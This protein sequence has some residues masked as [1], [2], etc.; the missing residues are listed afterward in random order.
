MKNKEY[1]SVRTGKIIPSKDIS[2]D[3]LKFMFT[4][5][6]NKLKI[7]GYFDKYF[8]MVCSD[9]G[10]IPGI[11]DE[12]INGE[13]FISLHRRNLYP[14]IQNLPEYDEDTLFDV[15]EFLHD[16]CSKGIK[17]HYHGFNQ[18]CLHFDEFDDIKGQEHFRQLFNVPLKIY[19]KGFEISESGEVLALADNGLTGLFE[20][21]KPSNDEQ[22]INNKI[23]AAIRKFRRHNCTLDERRD[24]VNELAGILEF[25]RPQM[26]KHIDRRDDIALFGIANEFGIRHHN[27]KQKTDYDQAV[28][29]SW[30]FYFYLA[31]IHAV[32]RLIER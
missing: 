16:N 19:K 28:W 26:S 32:L 17:G 30:M 8:G 22:N 10:Y 25:I 14:I 12:D 7:E 4:V 9:D 3:D 27:R 23:D 2:L 13:M 24:A 5:Q 15:I 20:A 11:L 21:Q 6:Y 31:T 29:Y 18:N 1:Y